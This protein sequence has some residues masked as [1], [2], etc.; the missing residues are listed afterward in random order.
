MQLHRR[1]IQFHIR[2]SGHLWLKVQVEEPR[3][4]Q[5]FPADTT[6]RAAVE[7]RLCPERTGRSWNKVGLRNARL[8]VLGL[9]CLKKNWRKT[10]KDLAL[11]AGCLLSSRPTS[12]E[13]DRTIDYPSLCQRT[14]H[15]R[16]LQKRQADGSKQKRG[17]PHFE[18]VLARTFQPKRRKKKSGTSDVTEHEGQACLWPSKSTS[19]FKRVFRR[20]GGQSVQVGEKRQRHI[21]SH[22]RSN[23]RGQY[24]NPTF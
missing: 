16:L 5:V 17:P 18:S 3:T 13:T 9:D 8:S 10:P 6:R 22:I 4:L 15:C 11:K 1:G 12:T 2:N 19:E 23:H 21:T 7:V 24:K 14:Y 20:R